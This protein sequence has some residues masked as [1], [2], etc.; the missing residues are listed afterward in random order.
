M[1][2]CNDVRLLRHRSLNLNIVGY[3]RMSIMVVQQFLWFMMLY[4]GQAGL[5]RSTY[6]LHRRL[7]SG[8]YIECSP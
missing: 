6:L 5:H 4:S 1:L 3:A 8:I 7:Y 2:A